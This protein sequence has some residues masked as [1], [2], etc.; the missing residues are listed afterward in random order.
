LA[1]IQDVYAASSMTIL[2]E[3]VDDSDLGAKADGIYQH[4]SA[5]GL[6]DGIIAGTYNPTLGLT[7]LN[8]N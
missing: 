7:A 1:I 2:A 6:S 5:W 4:S 8:G 3:S